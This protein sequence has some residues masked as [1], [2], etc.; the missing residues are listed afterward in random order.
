MVQGNGFDLF[1]TTLRDISKDLPLDC[2]LSIPSH[3]NLIGIIE[4]FPEFCNGTLHN[5][6]HTQNPCNSSG[7]YICKS[8]VNYLRHGNYICKSEENVPVIFSWA[9]EPSTSKRRTARER[10]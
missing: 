10:S 8:I 3:E 4:S 9:T 1:V 6:L 7:V 2:I 5:R